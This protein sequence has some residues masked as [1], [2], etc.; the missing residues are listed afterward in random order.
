MLATNTVRL[1]HHSQTCLPPS[2]NT[3]VDDNIFKDEVC[4]KQND[5]NCSNIVQSSF[6]I[7]NYAQY[8]DDNTVISQLNILKSQSIIPEENDKDIS[9]YD[10]MNT[11]FPN[12]DIVRVKNNNRIDDSLDEIMENISTTSSDISNDSYVVLEIKCSLAAQEMAYRSAVCAIDPVAGL[13]QKM[14]LIPRKIMKHSTAHKGEIEKKKKF[15]KRLRMNYPANRNHFERNSSYSSDC[16][17]QR[18]RLRTIQKVNDQ[19]LIQSSTKQICRPLK[20]KDF[21][22]TE[23]SILN[24]SENVHGQ[25]SISCIGSITHYSPPQQKKVLNR[26]DDAN[27]KNNTIIS[28]RYKIN[29]KTHH[30]ID[31]KIRSKSRITAVDEEKCSRYQQTDDTYSST[32]CKTELDLPTTPLKTFAFDQLA[33]QKYVNNVPTP[34]TSPTHDSIVQKSKATFPL[35]LS[36]A[37]AKKNELLQETNGNLYQVNPIQHDSNHLIVNTKEEIGRDTTSSKKITLDESVKFDYY[38]SDLMKKSH[39]STFGSVAR[40]SALYRLIKKH[41]QSGVT[42]HRSN[43]EPQL[44]EIKYANGKTLKDNDAILQVETAK[45]SFKAPTFSTS[46]SK[47][48]RFGIPSNRLFSRHQELSSIRELNQ[49]DNDSSSRFNFKAVTTRLSRLIE[50]TSSGTYDLQNGS[51]SRGNGIV[52]KQFDRVRTFVSKMAVVDDGQENYTSIEER[53]I[54][55]KCEIFSENFKT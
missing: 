30:E 15:T 44:I 52:R 40:N 37:L 45:K 10:E 6:G 2:L 11:K 13:K 17:N 27:T 50:T 53:S 51:F 3:G 5:A 25:S 12:N 7:N 35:H 43:S 20:R 42:G 24:P 48:N 19:P 9:Y 14:E 31:D 33:M 16:D 22:L 26:I 36:T 55:K 8:R 49:L 1:E 28:T 21:M 39:G 32:E 23:K 4:S 38:P 54:S 34:S 29:A 47:I 46:F 18:I 41:Y